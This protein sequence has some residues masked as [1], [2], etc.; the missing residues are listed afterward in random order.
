VRRAA[1][2]RISLHFDDYKLQRTP[3]SIYPLDPHQWLADGADP[4]AW[5]TPQLA[6]DVQHLLRGDS[7]VVPRH[8]TVLASKRWNVER[9]FGWIGRQRRLSRDYE[10]LTSTEEAF[11]YLVG[12][13]LLLAR[14][15]PA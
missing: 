7:V 4:N 15:A 9:T 12:I 3:P 14:M 2:Q 6:P 5:E 10:R 8:G 11:I 13:Q 1:V